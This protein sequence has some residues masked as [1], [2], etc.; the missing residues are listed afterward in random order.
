MILN[1]LFILREHQQG[2]ITKKELTKYKYLFLWDT[3]G[4]CNIITYQN[5]QFQDFSFIF[6]SPYGWRLIPCG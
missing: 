2:Y 1:Q 4:F 5:I 3:N 6:Q